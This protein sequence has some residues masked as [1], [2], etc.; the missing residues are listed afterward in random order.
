ME[1][2]TKILNEAAES[3]KGINSR[4]WESSEK[5]YFFILYDV[6]QKVKE[7]DPT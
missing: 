6:E 4:R 5:N 3:T 1:K 7:R 2:V